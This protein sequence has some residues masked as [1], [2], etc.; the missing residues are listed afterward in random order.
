MG[1]AMVFSLKKFTKINGDFV[2]GDYIDDVVVVYD[3]V[4]GCCVLIIHGD[5][6]MCRKHMVVC[7]YVGW[8][9]G[10]CAYDVVFVD[11]LDDVVVVYDH[12]CCCCV[13]IIHGDILVPR[14]YM[15]VCRLYLA[16]W[17]MTL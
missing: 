10:M 8:P 5:N 1:F 4:C 2:L 13:L 17:R 14:N 12:V 7:M 15:V 9:N 6:L 3:H 11:Y 16:E